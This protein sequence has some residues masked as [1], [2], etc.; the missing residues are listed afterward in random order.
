MR[1]SY[2]G[3]EARLR[4]WKV[5]TGKRNRASSDPCP[6]R[7]ERIS[8]KSCAAVQDMLTEPAIRYLWGTNRYHRECFPNA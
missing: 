3:T 2:C 6:G 8:P 1:I 7:P 4:E 5:E